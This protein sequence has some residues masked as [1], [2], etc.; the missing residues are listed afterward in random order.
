M[1]LQATKC[2][3]SF[4]AFILIATALAGAAKDAAQKPTTR[5]NLKQ[6][7]LA[8]MMYA[9]DYDERLPPMKNT[10]A[11]KKVIG[12]YLDSD[13]IFIDPATKK[14]F[15]FNS[16]LSERNVEDIWK[17]GY[18]K[19][20]GIIAIYQATPQTSGER[21]VLR[22]ARA[23]RLDADGRPILAY[24]CD[25]GIYWEP[26]VDSISLKQWPS[27]KKTSNIP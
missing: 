20:Q 1:K 22:M 3:F 8:L 11:L 24:T 4:S 16:S 18:E 17:E 26:T 12:P 21:L 23:Y 5:G 13:A 6:L 10:A 9:Q 19:K 27:A 14:A 25:N 2:I 7:G 15:A